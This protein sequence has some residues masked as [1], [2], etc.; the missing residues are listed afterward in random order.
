MNYVQQ[1]RCCLAPIISIW[2]D[3]VK[4]QRTEM[5]S[6]SNCIFMIVT[7]APSY[8]F[9]PFSSPVSYFRFLKRLMNCFTRNDALTP[10]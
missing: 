5:S 7:S 6:L 8:S 10:T 4:Q 9:C 1:I 3:T 2:T